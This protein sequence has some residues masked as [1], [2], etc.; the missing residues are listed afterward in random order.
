[1]HFARGILGERSWIAVY[2][3]S[4]ACFTAFIV[5]STNSPNVWCLPYF[6]S[7]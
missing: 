5:M 2:S 4:D 6:F 3:G 1:V 7:D